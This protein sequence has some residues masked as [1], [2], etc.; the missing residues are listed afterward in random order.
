MGKCT[1]MTA[2]VVGALPPFA[3]IGICRLAMLERMCILLLRIGRELRGSL[4]VPLL[5]AGCQVDGEVEMRGRGQNND[6]NS[7]T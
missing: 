3:R 6:N 4:P 7:K 1:N 2:L 5:G